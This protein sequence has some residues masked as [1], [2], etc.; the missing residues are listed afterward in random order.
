[1]LIFALVIR[2]LNDAKINGE[3]CTMQNR[4]TNRRKSRLLNNIHLQLPTDSNTSSSRSSPCSDTKRDLW[5]PG[6]LPSR[7]P[8]KVSLSHWFPTHHHTGEHAHTSMCK[9][10]CWGC[11]GTQRLVH[12][13]PATPSHRTGRKERER[14]WRDEREGG[15]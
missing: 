10:G 11:N 15:G 14:N 2:G 7:V 9:G 13:S 8:S 12:P 3:L 1:M 5:L 4:L 6:T